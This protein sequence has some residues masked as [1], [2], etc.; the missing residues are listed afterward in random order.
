M[1]EAFTP[2]SLADEMGDEPGRDL[3]EEERKEQRMIARITAAVVAAMQ[4][5]MTTNPPTSISPLKTIPAN[6]QFKPEEIR[7]FNPELD[8]EE[9]S[10]VTEDKLWIHDVF[11]FIQQIKDIASIHDKETIHFNLLLCL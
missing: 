3:T 4:N 1:V 11:I 10:V 8:T 5:A 2:E 7:F 6:K 9:D